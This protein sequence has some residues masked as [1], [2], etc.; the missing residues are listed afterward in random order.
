MR[1]LDQKGFGF[2][3]WL[4]ILLLLILLILA[5]W[6][7][8]KNQQK[9]KQ[10]ASSSQQQQST[11]P[12]NQPEEKKYLKIPEMGLKVELSEK[13]EDAY[14][15][16]HPDGWAYMSVKSLDKYAG[17]KANAETGMAAIASAKVGDDNFGEPY[18][19]AQLKAKGTKIGEKYYWIDLGQYDCTADANGENGDPNFEIVRS[20]FTKAKISAL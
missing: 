12:A 15:A 4:L 11:Q 10:S 18:T 1:K 7:V 2:F 5:S 20:A 16:M 9:K 19:E 13:I 17:C 6:Y 8:Y 14:Y 3:Y